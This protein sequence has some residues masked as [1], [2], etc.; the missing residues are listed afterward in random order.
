MV[1]CGREG[2]NKRFLKKK[3]K[4]AEVIPPRVEE[5]KLVPTAEAKGFPNPAPKGAW[6][7]ETEREYINFTPLNGL[8]V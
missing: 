1:N 6:V 7:P 4:T 8:S 5:P 2:Q 3:Q